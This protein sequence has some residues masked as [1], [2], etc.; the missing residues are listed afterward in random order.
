MG[1][2][3][4]EIC[5]TLNTHP[6]ETTNIINRVIMLLLYLRA[7]ET[8]LF[9]NPFQSTTTTTTPS[10][11]GT[12][13]GVEKFT[14]SVNRSPRNS[15]LKPNDPQIYA[16]ERD[17]TSYSTV[18]KSSFFFLTRKALN[19]ILMNVNFNRFCFSL[20]KTDSISSFTTNK[21]IIN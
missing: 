3:N 9:E 7:H 6:A 2:P 15:N 5:Y 8:L 19:S 17:S 20:Q 4:A 14:F 10:L 18:T 21:R 13:V 11:S 12:E 16:N 1:A